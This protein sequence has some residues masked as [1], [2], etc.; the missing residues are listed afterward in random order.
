MKDPRVEKQVRSAIGNSTNTR[1][2]GHLGMVVGYDRY[3]NTANVMLSKPSSVEPGEVLTGLPCP[4]VPGVQ[5]VAPEHGRLC[6]V[7][8]SGDANEMA[9]ITH[10]FSSSYLSTDYTKQSNA[11]SSIPKFVLEM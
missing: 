11:V 10:F 6:W 2:I 3:S 5:Y 7:E 8:F 4:Y 1:S 9:V